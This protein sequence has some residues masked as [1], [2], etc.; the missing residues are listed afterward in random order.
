MNFESFEKFYEYFEKY[1]NSKN[2]KFYNKERLREYYK[3]S[4]NS[5]N[6]NEML[7]KIVAKDYKTGIEYELFGEGSYFYLLPDINSSGKID[8]SVNLEA[9][10]FEP[11]AFQ[12]LIVKSGNLIHEIYYFIEDK[13]CIKLYDTSAL[14]YIIEEGHLSYREIFDLDND[15]IEKIGVYP[16]REELEH[17]FTSKR[18]VSPRYLLNEFIKSNIKEENKGIKELNELNQNI[19]KYNETIS[20]LIKTLKEND[21]SELKLKKT[22]KE[23]HFRMIED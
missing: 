4:C 2:I 10:A 16:D 21:N 15:S 9:F 23:K 8:P 6:Y 11:R 7:N 13:L 3:G 17:Y 1:F 19:I 12:T 18:G 20:E 5:F 14:K 22:L